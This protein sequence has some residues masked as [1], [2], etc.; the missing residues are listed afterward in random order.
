[1][2]GAGGR[3]DRM[4]AGR[5]RPTWK[6]GKD[7]QHQSDD[8]TCRRRRPRSG[9]TSRT[10]TRAPRQAERLG[11]ANATDPRMRRSGKEEGEDKKKKSKF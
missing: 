6:G 8:L 9:W 4:A 7:G 1:M 3:G 5:R 10:S 11:L 2:G